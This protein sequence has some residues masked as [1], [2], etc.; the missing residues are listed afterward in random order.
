MQIAYRS[1]LTR[2]AVALGLALLMATS[3]HET[4]AQETVRIGVGVDPVFTPWWIAEEK[5]FYRKHGVKAEIT[6][7]S[8]GPALSDATMAGE[9]DIGSSGTA[10]WMPRI[11]RG[12]MV[13]LGTMATSPDALKMAALTSIKSMNDLVGKKVGSVAGSSTDYLWVL[14]AKKLNVPETAVQVVGM[15]PPELVPSL[16]RGDIQAYFV[17]EPWATRAVEVSGKNKV[18]ILAN[19]GDVG[20]FLNFIVAANK[21]FVE[22][23]PDTT[24]KILAALRDAIDFQNRN[25]AEAARIGGE[26]NKLKPDMASSIINL[27]QYSLGIAPEMEAAAKTEEAWM[28]SKERLRGEPIDWSKTIDRRYLDRALAMQ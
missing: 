26:K 22:A 18:H 7:F 28:R 1:I 13:V 12:S 11:V 3:T 9:M 16:D 17:W 2:F 23:K 6:Q 5:G 25:P 10:T 27:Y 21:K 4:R 24:V 20:Y 8:G 19:S 14:F 15:P